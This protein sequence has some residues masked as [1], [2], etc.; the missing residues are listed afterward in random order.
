MV[1]KEPDVVVNESELKSPV[2][3]EGELVQLVRNKPSR[4]AFLFKVG[5][6]LNVVA[7]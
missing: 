6:A 1:V 4:R 2:V 7:A 5:A 3:T